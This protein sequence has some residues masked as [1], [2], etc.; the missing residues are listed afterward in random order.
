MCCCYKYLP[1]IEVLCE[2]REL[3]S[4]ILCE[5]VTVYSLK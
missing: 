1:F 5:E 3:N 4:M 2:L